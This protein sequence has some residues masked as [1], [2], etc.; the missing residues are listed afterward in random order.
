M[1]LMCVQCVVES[2][3]QAAMGWFLASSACCQ[4]HVGVSGYTLS[5]LAFNDHTN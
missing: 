3:Y 5:Y 2:L 4:A 1:T